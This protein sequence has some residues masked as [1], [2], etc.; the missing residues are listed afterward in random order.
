MDPGTACIHAVPGCSLCIPHQPA[1]RPPDHQRSLRPANLCRAIGTAGVPSPSV[2][3]LR[4]ETAWL[5][6]N[7]V[8]NLIELQQDP[9]TGGNVS[10]ELC[11]TR[12]WTSRKGLLDMFLQ[13]INW[14]FDKA[15]DYFTNCLQ[16][17]Y[18]VPLQVNPKN[19]NLGQMHVLS[20]ELCAFASP[21][22]RDINLTLS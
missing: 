13:S 14:A 8:L 16:K 2:D 9:W 20:C 1:P 18:T 17:D 21:I 5:L 22:V 12:E 6:F 3:W 4:P 19:A 10:T 7:Q 11:T 15:S